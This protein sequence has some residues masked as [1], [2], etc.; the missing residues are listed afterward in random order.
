V[1]GPD[2]L[3]VSGGPQLAQLQE[4]AAATSS[5]CA[6]FVYVLQYCNASRYITCS[7]N[8]KWWANSRV[9]G[10]LTGECTGKRRHPLHDL[11]KHMQVLAFGLGHREVHALLA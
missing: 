7:H 11:Q 6:C 4:V 1:R 8:Q 5:E 2:V 3:L 9:S 10:R